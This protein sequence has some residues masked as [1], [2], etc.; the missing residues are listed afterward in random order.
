MKKIWWIGTGVMGNPM[1]GHL[2]HA[3]HEV[4]VWNRTK[5]KTDNLIKEWA[6]YCSSVSELSQKADIIFT[7]I[8]D[9]QNVRD[10]Y[11]WEE[12]IIEN[13]AEWSILV[14]M[15]TTEPSLAREIF[16][17]SAQKW[18]SSL[19]A[20]VSWG[21]VGAKNG[22]L[23]IMVWGTQDAFDAVL[24]LFDLLW[25]SVTHIGEAG[26]G[27]STKMANQVAIAGN[28]IAL[29]ESLLYAERSGLDLETTIEVFKAGWANNWGM[30]NLAP[31]IVNNDFDT[32][33]FVKH[34]VKDMR[35][36][37][38]ECKKMNLTLPGL[39]M[40][41]DLYSYMLSYNEGDLWL[42]ALYLSLKR[43]NNI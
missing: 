14:D 3:G 27:Q 41:H 13:A 11:F 26:T 42:Q 17:L 10:T 39:S 25:A 30:H 1:V 2:I 8:W 31:R 22:T 29:C 34:F 35:I 18:I 16:E 4:Y 15:T 5:S 9:P 21:D 33:F 36:A 40:V 37:L 23:S 12:G 24:P 20:P 38:E 19:D 43:M 6:T 32:Y 7:I 28:M